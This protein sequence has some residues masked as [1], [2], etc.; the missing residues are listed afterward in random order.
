[1]T[2]TGLGRAPVVDGAGAKRAATG[3]IA[4]GLE[5][6]RRSSLPPSPHTRRR[7]A[8]VTG[9]S[10]PPHHPRARVSPRALAAR[11]RASR[12]VAAISP[13]PRAIVRSAR[14]AARKIRYPKK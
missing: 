6:A 11:A 12:R 9:A 5:E 4:G 1:M 3:K 2:R 10:S 14:R 13:L 8:R 7:R